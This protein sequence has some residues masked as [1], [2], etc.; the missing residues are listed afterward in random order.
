MPA[1]RVDGPLRWAAVHGAG[2]A[3]RGGG[4]KG[5]AGE[6][7]AQRVGAAVCGF[8]GGDVVVPLVQAR[9]VRYRVKLD[10]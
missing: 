10:E 3:C 2:T 4:V 8:S 7:P 9:A 6:V 1:Q 5:G